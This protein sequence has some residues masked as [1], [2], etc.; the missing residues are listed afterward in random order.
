MTDSTATYQ[1]LFAELKRRNVFRVMAVYG[2]VGFVVLQVVDLL[3]PALL[4]PEWTYRLVAVLLL[5]GFPVAVVLAWAF[6][7]TP[8]GLKR[9]A[10]ADPS[11]I[12]AIVAAPAGRRWSSGLL[13]LLGMGLLLGAW[14]MGRQGATG[15]GGVAEAE[16]SP[17]VRLA[18][19]A[20]ARDSLPTIAVLPF[21]DLS[22]EGDQR[23]FSDGMTEEILNTLAKVREL[24]VA[25]RTSAFAFRGRDLDMRTIGDSLGVRYLIE[26]SVRKDGNELRITAQLIDGSDGTHLWSESYNRQMNDVFAIQTEIAEAVAQELRVPLGLD[27]GDQLVSPTADLEAYDL[28]LAGRARMRERGEGVQEAVKMFGA[29]IARDSAWAPAWAGLAESQAL[30]PYYTPSD[31]ASFANSLEAAEHA[32]ERALALDPNNAS[33]LVAL[34]NV[35]RDRWD[36]AAAEDYYVRA[37]T[38]DPENVEALQQYSEYFS[39]IGRLDEAYRLARRALALDRSPIRLNNGGL[40]ARLNGRYE[41]ARELLDEGIRDDPDFRVWALRNNLAQL[42]ATTG[43]WLVYRRGLVEFL[44]A[45]RDDVSTPDS[46]RKHIAEDLEELEESWPADSQPTLETARLLTEWQLSVAAQMYLTFGD[47]ERA[48]KALE[49]SFRDRDRIGDPGRGLYE[50]TLDPLRDDPRFEAILAA[51]GI[52][53]RR[54][55]RLPPDA[56]AD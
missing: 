23:Y 13:A 29:A 22:P 36:W 16:A 15:S 3:I 35:H 33:A 34:G 24:K 11:E 51:H 54:P 49:I 5:V 31:S 7:Q 14:W 52:A 37:L 30:L 17:T 8:A 20:E 12:Q 9:T 10:P 27:S 32:A 21:L 45:V 2:I 38:L 43:D 4:L 46:D 39:Y 1:R 41:E 44:T 19:A 25:A 26:G 18:M 40:M 50:S 48:M 28:Y 56:D 42:E 47:R 55:V 6:E 53:G